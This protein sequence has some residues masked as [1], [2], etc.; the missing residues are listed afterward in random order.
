MSAEYRQYEFNL[1]V[2]TNTAWSSWDWSSFTDTNKKLRIGFPITDDSNFYEWFNTNIVGKRLI[3]YV[4]GLYEAAAY[5]L[6]SVTPFAYNRV[7]GFL[8]PAGSLTA[9]Q[10]IHDNFPALY[11]ADVLNSYISNYSNYIFA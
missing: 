10:S 3:N 9:S 7:P 11:N 6:N 2:S 1:Y 5:A 4:T 8:Y